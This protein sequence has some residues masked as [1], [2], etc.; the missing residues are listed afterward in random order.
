MELAEPNVVV[1]KARRRNEVNVERRPYLSST[2]M[3]SSAA[4]RS[5]RR[6]IPIVCRTTCAARHAI[7]EPLRR[8]RLERAFVTEQ[9]FAPSGDVAHLPHA[10]RNASEVAV[11]PRPSFGR[12]MARIPGA[13]CEVKAARL[14]GALRA[15]RTTFARAAVRNEPDAGECESGI[16]DEAVHDGA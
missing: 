1:Q 12:L 14:I 2:T 11:R 13:R 9:R 8:A 15:H 5:S 10:E 6:E 16:C 7:A 3:K 4:R